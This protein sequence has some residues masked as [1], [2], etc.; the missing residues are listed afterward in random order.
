MI[1]YRARVGVREDDR[2]AGKVDGF[3]RGAVA[4]MRAADHHPDLVHDRNGP[5]AEIGEAARILV[6]T[7]TRCRVGLV[8]GKKHPANAE[9]I[10]KRNEIDSLV[11]RV[12]ALDVEADPEPVRGRGLLDIGGGAAEALFVA[13]AVNT[14]R[15]EDSRDGQAGITT[16]RS[17]WSQSPHK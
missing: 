3:P 17:R 15:P 9:I 1:I 16:D 14:P 13:M 6:E 5:A 4:R 2:R 11:E 8:I 10:V 7:S 12:H